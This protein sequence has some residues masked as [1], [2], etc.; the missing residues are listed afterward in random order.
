MGQM[1]RD[2]S[3]L[4]FETCTNFYKTN[5]CFSSSVVAHV[6]IQLKTSLEKNL[7]A[8]KIESVEFSCFYHIPLW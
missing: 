6:Q 4:L 1:G 5:T 7:T 2:F 3:Q 8:K